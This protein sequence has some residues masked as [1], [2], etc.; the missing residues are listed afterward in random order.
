MRT[1]RE[2]LQSIICVVPKIKIDQVQSNGDVAFRVLLKDCNFQK[3]DFDNPIT[4]T[5]FF[6]NFIGELLVRDNINKFS[7]ILT[8]LDRSLYQKMICS[9]EDHKDFG[10]I[11]DDKWSSIT[12]LMH[13]SLIQKIVTENFDLNLNS[14]NMV[15]TFDQSQPDNEDN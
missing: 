6:V 15:D 2:I 8:N 5:N 9:D 11:V 12:F 7:I 13:L 14:E 4:K 1:L 10:M 3:E